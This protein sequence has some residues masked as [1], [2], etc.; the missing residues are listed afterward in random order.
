MK[1]EAGF[2]IRDLQKGRQARAKRDGAL[3][4]PEKAFNKHLNSSLEKKQISGSKAQTRAAQGAA[5]T[6]AIQDLS[7][8]FTVDEK[9]FISELFGIG[10]ASRLAND[11]NG[12]QDDP[13]GSVGRHVDLSA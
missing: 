10:D 4:E 13:A 1:V 11:F 2:P 9:R 8:I 12:S 5:K 3:R 6:N 7:A